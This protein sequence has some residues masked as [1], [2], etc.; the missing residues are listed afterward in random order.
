MFD[1]FTKKR[2]SGLAYNAKSVKQW[3]GE[4]RKLKKEAAKVRDADEKNNK[5][6]AKQELEKLQLS[7]LSHL[8]GEDNTF[9]TLLREAREHMDD[10]AENQEIIVAIEE[11]KSSFRDTKRALFKFFTHYTNPDVQLD[12]KFE[13]EFGAIV[14][15][16]VERIEFEETTLY[17]MM[18]R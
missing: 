6:K 2:G 7:T 13:E 5:I 3:K 12:K 11:F 16:L 4:H 18:D 1:Y 14:D 9:S 17:S 8:M 10:S 15:A